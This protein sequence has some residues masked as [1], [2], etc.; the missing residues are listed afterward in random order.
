MK[1]VTTAKVYTIDKTKVEEFITKKANIADDQKIYEMKDPFIENFTNTASG[2]TGKL[3]TSYMTGP[4]V[5]V[6]S[7]VDLIKGRGLGDAQHVLK[8]I[9]GVTDV[10]INTSFP[11]VTSIPSDTNKITVELDVKDQ[12]GN[13]VEESS[14]NAEEGE[15]ESKSSETDKKEEN[16][17]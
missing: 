8:D 1:A 11:W 17:E 5:S 12:S 4:K 14:E 10:H 9:D 13:K 15:D 7:V 16:K 6:S 2:F 3:K